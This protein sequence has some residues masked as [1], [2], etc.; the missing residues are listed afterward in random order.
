MH[1]EELRI[2][3]QAASGIGMPQNHAPDISAALLIAAHAVAEPDD[4][5]ARRYFV[6]FRIHALSH[7]ETLRQLPHTKLREG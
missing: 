1:Q 2:V 4:G 3:D 5:Q 6:L 7:R